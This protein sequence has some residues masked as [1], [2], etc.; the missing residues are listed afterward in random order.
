MHR[1]PVKRRLALEPQQWDWGSSGI[2]L[3]ASAASLPVNEE[4][5]AELKVWKIA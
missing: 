3:T 2:M 4:R 5:R 1:N